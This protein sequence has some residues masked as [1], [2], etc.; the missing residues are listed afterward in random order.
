MSYVGLV[1]PER[2][3]TFLGAPVESCN[4]DVF[5]ADLTTGK[6]RRLTSHPEY[7]D[8]VDLS[9]DDKW[10][11]V[12]DTRG[13]DRLMFVAAL[14]GIPPL[15]DLVVTGAVSSIR[16]NGV[17]RFFE[18]WLIDQYG[19][20]GSYFGQKINAEGSGIPGSGAIN[21]PDWNGRADPRWSRDGTQIAYTQIIASSPACG[22][23]NPLPCHNSTESG[24]RDERIM[25]AHLTSRKLLQL[26]AVEPRS[27]IVPWGQPF[28]PGAS[29][30]VIES[31]PPGN[32]TLKGKVSGWA[33]VSL[34][35]LY[36]G[37]PIAKV[38]VQY[39]N[40]SIDG[41]NV[42]GGYENVWKENPTPYDEFVHWYSNLTQTGP[43]NGTKITSADGFHLLI[44]VDLN[45]FE[46]NGTLI[47]TIDG[48]EYHQPANLT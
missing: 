8:P 45:F 21:D 41:L 47:T 23:N 32:Y 2:G 36:D 27:D 19:D 46:A 42:L 29:Y 34:D 11:V 30:P 9:P 31:L 26:P 13:T 28:P 22:G 25:I 40:Y 1:E 5:A 48:K 35:T 33:D 7:A 17:R 3:L 10:T 15:I 39:Y 20:R 44:S 16:N 43:N 6:T 14:R 18:P 37:G 38:S 4:I 12:L 24:G